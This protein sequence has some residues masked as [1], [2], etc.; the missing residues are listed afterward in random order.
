MQQIQQDPSD[1]PLIINL[2]NENI[3]LKE[4]EQALMEA[5]EELSLQNED[6]LYKLKESMQRELESSSKR[7]ALVSQNIFSRT[8]ST[9]PSIH[10]SNM[11]R[12][13]SEPNVEYAQN[14]SILKKKKKKSHY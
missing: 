11:L 14:K 3:R 9:L 1:N 7:A 8:D 12:T 5:V 6:L 2:E 10:E 13:N 4:R